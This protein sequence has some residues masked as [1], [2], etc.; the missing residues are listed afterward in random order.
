MI[1]GV[2]KQAARSCLVP[3][4][5]HVQV[6]LCCSF[7]GFDSRNPSDSGFHREEFLTDPPHG[8]KRRRQGRTFEALPQPGNGQSRP[9]E[10]GGRDDSSAAGDDGGTD[11]MEPKQKLQ[12]NFRKRKREQGKEEQADSEHHHHHHGKK[13]KRRSF[14]STEETRA[15]AGA[16]AALEEGKKRL[17]EILFDYSRR[18]KQQQQQHSSRNRSNF[19]PHDSRLSVDK[20]ALPLQPEEAALLEELNSFQ[21]FQLQSSTLTVGGSVPAPQNNAAMNLFFPHHPTTDGK[22]RGTGDEAAAV[23]GGMPLDW[24]LKTGIRILSPRSMDWCFP[25]SFHGGNVGLQSFLQVS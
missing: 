19:F 5:S 1:G 14:G 8:M 24:S 2:V 7:E 23:G 11:E 17:H 16:E 25:S 3:S 13:H 21:G 18:Q 6:A 22:G 10:E 9:S 4:S 15:E 20:D 12:R